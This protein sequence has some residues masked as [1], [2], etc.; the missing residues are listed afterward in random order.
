[1]PPLVGGGWD[2]DWMAILLICRT[3][4]ASGEFIRNT[5]VNLIGGNE[6]ALASPTGTRP[7]DRDTTLEFVFV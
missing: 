6:R 2:G 5:P 3:G 1:M 4:L 7:V